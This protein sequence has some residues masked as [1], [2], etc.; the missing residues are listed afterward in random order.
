LLHLVSKV[1]IAIHQLLLNLATTVNRQPL[2]P[3]PES[4]GI[5]LPPER[6]RLTAVNFDIVPRLQNGHDATA[7]G[8][9]SGELFS[10]DEDME[11]KVVNSIGETQTSVGQGRRN[12]EDEEYD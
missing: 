8:D 11:E 7:G 4:Y 10:G 12:E 5:R 3:I 6:E 9:A 1:L 2:P